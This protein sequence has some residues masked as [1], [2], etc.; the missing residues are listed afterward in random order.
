MEPNPRLEQIAAQ[1]TQAVYD[2]SD[3]KGSVGALMKAGAD[4]LSALQSLAP[5]AAHDY[6]GDPKHCHACAI[7]AFVNAELRTREAEAQL[8]QVTRE[9]DALRKE[10]HEERAV[11]IC[12]CPAGDH[13]NYGE[14]G[15]SCP[16]EDHQCLRV[17][18]GAAAVVATLR[19]Q[20]A[21]AKA[22]ALREAADASI[23]E[24]VGAF[25]AERFREWLRQRAEQEK[26]R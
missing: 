20:L 1:W 11:C 14:D 19:A 8:E 16:H 22:D 4:L 3:G 13:E 26:Q 17:C 7:R 5:P 6:T 2:Y 18:R 12:G 25:N 10:L 24:F 21:S 15:E 9:R 23:D